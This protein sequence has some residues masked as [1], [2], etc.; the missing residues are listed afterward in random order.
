MKELLTADELA[1]YEAAQDDAAKAS[2]LSTVKGRIASEH[3]STEDFWDK[4][5]IPNKVKDNIFKKDS[6]P[7]LKNEVLTKIFDAM[8]IPQFPQD[9]PL[10]PSELVAHV[11]ANMTNNG[12]NEKA[13]VEKVNKMV[14]E[15]VAEYESSQK[16]ASEYEKA[17]E[18]AWAEFAVAGFDFRK[19]D[20]KDFLENLPEGVA[21]VRENDSIALK[22]GEFDY[23][24]G[25]KKMTIKDLATNYAKVN[26]IAEVVQNE[27]K[28]EKEKVTVKIEDGKHHSRNP[29]A[30]KKNN[31]FYNE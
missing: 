13:I 7:R 4:V 19:A 10:T 26:K 9:K 22:K 24:V 15:K 18:L 5:N 8:G 14:A 28:K 30:N 6:L 23:A 25:G 31:E 11:S 27:Q 1:A 21:I 29:N 17:K 2:I 20:F 3:T 12:D 16:K